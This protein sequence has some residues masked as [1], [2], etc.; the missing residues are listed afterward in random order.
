MN[1]KKWSITLIVSFFILLI[2]LG[3]VVVVLD[4]YF[5]YHAPLEGLAYVLGPAE[6]TNDG[7]SKHFSYQAMITGTSMTR[8]FQPDEA[9]TLFDKE[10]IRITYLGEGFKRINDNLQAAINANPDL[11]LVIRG[12]DPIWFVTDKN[13]LGYDDYPEYLY[14]SN[15][16]NDVNYLYNKDIF[17]GGVVPLMLRTIHNET[18][19]LFN[20]VPFM[21]EQPGGKELVLAEYDRPEKELK[22]IDQAE[23]DEFFRMM[24][25]NLEENVI[26]TITANPDITFYLFI[27]PYSI[28]WW[29][30]LNQYGTDVLL[31]RI[32]MERA[33]LEKLLAYDNVRLFS[34]SNNF[35]LT[36]NLDNYVD[37]IHYHG[38]VSSKI[39][40]WMKEGKYELTL[41]NYEEYI[42]EI[43]AF[44]T[45]YDYDGIFE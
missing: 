19:T 42:E 1:G 21:G 4:P 40:H 11:E 27:P 8:D 34:F 10:F 13:W 37:D 41:E 45:T 23:T 38:G 30:G 44:Y 32:A 12:I 15:L 6:Y 39:L 28:C 5:H 3:G 26:S 9:E 17:W 14:D 31:R 16:W 36:C 7:I 18:S 20:P 25:E 29:D 43:T 35:E 22:A 33:A 2:G 24:N